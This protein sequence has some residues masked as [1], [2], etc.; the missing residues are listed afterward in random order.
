MR[1]AI[2]GA[3]FAGLSVTWYLLHYTQGSVTIDL[4]DPEPIGGGASGLSSGLLHAYGGKNAKESWEAYRCLKETHRLMTEASRA[5][6][7]PLIVSKGILRPA[8]T[9]DQIQ[10]FQNSAQTYPDNE[11]WEKERCESTV[12]GLT[13]PADGGCLFIKN[14]LTLDAQAYLQGLWQ[15]CA[16]LGTQF[17]Q[18]AMIRKSDLEPYDRVLIAMGPMT[19]NFP[20]LKGIPITPI[21]GQV[22]DLEWP[23]GVKSPPFSLISKKYLVMH[24]DGKRCTVG[25][26]YEH[27]FDSP[28]PN[29]EKAS[30]EIM[31]QIV[32]FFPALKEAKVIRCRA[33]FRASTS[34]RLPIVGKISDKTYFFTGLGSKGLLYH[35]WVG[36]RV[37]RALLT[38]DPKHFPEEAYFPLEPA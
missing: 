37:A 31:P 38:K 30:E 34:S 21:K 12:P 35:A 27:E 4:F 17:H 24:P 9:E 1:F 8:L 33:G 14:G 13:L 28:Q 23:S 7:Q 16:L 29:L 10:N 5:L 36:K 22:I 20:P 11:W 32:D 26:T 18:Q 15:A 6:D 3:G 19:K 2:L 25:S